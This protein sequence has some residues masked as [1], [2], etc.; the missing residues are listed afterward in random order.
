MC[1]YVF[2]LCY[3]LHGYITFQR[4]RD[5]LRVRACVLACVN[6]TVMRI[7]ACAR[8]C[9]PHACVRARM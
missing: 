2:C 8:A 6:V 7:R 9:M 4:E 3:V 1:A 5:L